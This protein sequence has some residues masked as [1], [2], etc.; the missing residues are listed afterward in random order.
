MDEDAKSR[1][2]AGIK[3]KYK[4]EEGRYCRS[5]HLEDGLLNDERL[6]E[7]YLVKLSDKQNV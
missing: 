7:S 4:N 2:V 6:N 5:E 3:S 1:L